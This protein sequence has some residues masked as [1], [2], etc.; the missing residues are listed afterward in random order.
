MRNKFEEKV[1]KQLGS[2]FEYEPIKLKYVTE[3]VYTP[4]FVDQENKIIVESKGYFEP[5]DRK[6]MVS[7]KKCHPDWRII[8]CFQNPDKKLTKTSK[9][10]YRTWAEKHG[11]EVMEIK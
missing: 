4:D 2:D 7:V 5:G 10:T 1:A 11:F 8:L 3:Y 9:M 6:K